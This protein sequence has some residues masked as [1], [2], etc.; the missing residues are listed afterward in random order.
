MNKAW[1]YV[2]LGGILEVFWALCLKKAAGFTN[3]TYSILTI[4]LVVIS[5]LLFS[6]GMKL[7]PSG[8]AYTVFTGIGAIGTIF[9][10]IL[11]LGESVHFSKIFFS[12]LLIL[13]VISLKLTSKEENA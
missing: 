12:F 13:G 9:F 4:I 10:G 7:L 5:F 1:S 6:K 11:F 3:L 8:V 2:I